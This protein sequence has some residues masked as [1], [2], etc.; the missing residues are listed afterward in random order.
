MDI[1]IIE[2]ILTWIIC[3]EKIIIRQRPACRDIVNVIGT[4][5]EA[6]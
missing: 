4:I 1:I 3:Q 5:Q 6:L 2:Y